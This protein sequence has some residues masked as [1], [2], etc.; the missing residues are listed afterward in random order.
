MFD[1]CLATRRP[2]QTFPEY[3]LS[4]WDN[5]RLVLRIRTC[6]TST[7]ALDKME[8]YRFRAARAGLKSVK[9]KRQIFQCVRSPKK[10]SIVQKTNHNCVVKKSLYQSLICLPAPALP[11]TN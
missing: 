10:G 8:K 9:R 7:R 6:K 11:W 3:V 1:P 5:P 2:T 4:A